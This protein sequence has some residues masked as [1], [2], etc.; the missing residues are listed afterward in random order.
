M[1]FVM[2]LT[3]FLQEKLTE[4]SSFCLQQLCQRQLRSFIGNG[5]C[6]HFS[7][8]VERYDVVL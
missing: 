5:Y 4:H 1:L 2:S 7:S 6:N 8:W 3:R